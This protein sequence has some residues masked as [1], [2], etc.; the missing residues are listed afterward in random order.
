M[1]ATVVLPET[2]VTHDI[3]GINVWDCCDTCHETNPYWVIETS[4]SGPCETTNQTSLFLTGSGRVVATYMYH[5]E[6]VLSI[7]CLLF[8]CCYCKKVETDITKVPGSPAKGNR[9]SS[10]PDS[11]LSPRV[12]SENSEKESCIHIEKEPLP[13]V[14]DAETTYLQSLSNLHCIWAPR[15]YWVTPCGLWISC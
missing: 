6:C 15:H 10:P 4:G 1:Y 7:N 14:T 11:P 12:A 13:P 3:C 5:M 9:R 2:N 8:S